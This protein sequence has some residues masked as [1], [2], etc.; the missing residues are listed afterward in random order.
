M[1]INQ[2]QLG[3]LNTK[4]PR[5]I[6]R[7]KGWFGDFFSRDNGIGKQRVRELRGKVS[8]STKLKGRKGE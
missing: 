1:G 7:N 6:A 5:D 4:V 2:L 8:G 3:I